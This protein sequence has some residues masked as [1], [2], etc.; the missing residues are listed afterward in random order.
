VNGAE[1]QRLEMPMFFLGFLALLT[2]SEQW[3]FKCVYT[4]VQL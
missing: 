1:L 4:E 3:A 2:I